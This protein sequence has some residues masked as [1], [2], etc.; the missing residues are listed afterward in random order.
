M[1]NRK[2]DA[3]ISPADVQAIKDALTVIR[4][5]LPFLVK[6]S[7]DERRATFK[8]GP[9]SIS[10]LQ[11]ALAA[12][13]AHPDIFPT[14]F[15]QAAFAQDVELLESMSDVNAQV[16]S[17]ASA[18]DDTRMAVGGEAMQAGVQVYEY[19]RAAEKTQPGLKPLVD[20]LGERFQKAGKPKKPGPPST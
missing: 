11:N 7:V 19:V 8:A 13:R 14:T 6:L 2:I 1:P 20:R 15:D 18:I 5:K 4:T 9:D 12:V 16:D 17:V 10:F 3:T